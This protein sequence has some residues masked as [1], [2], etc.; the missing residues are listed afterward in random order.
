M[1]L[2]GQ[3]FTISAGEFEAT[4]VEVGAGLRRLTHRGVDL[5]VSY[6]EDRLP[7]KCCGVA[8][9]P[10]PNRIRH[11][12]YVF[13]GTEQQLAL[14]EPDKGNA[15][16]GFGRWSRWRPTV[17]QPS[18]VTLEFDVPPQKGYPFEVRVELTY[19][20]H[21]E[22]GL[23]VT[24]SAH[25]HGRGPAPFGAGFHPYLST[26]GAGLD[27]THIS[28]PARQRL[29]LDDAGVPVGVQ[30]VAGTPYDLR[31]GKRLKDL[32]M[33]A[34]FTGLD[35][36][37]GR[38]AAEVWSSGGGARLWFDATFRYLQVF[39]LDDVE[40]AGPGIAIEPMTCAAD[41]FNSTEGLIVL[42]PGGTWGGS[43]GIQPL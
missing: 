24:A 3:Q 42:H 8:L 34:G 35:L 25:N 4:I 2:T 39:T 29:L 22:L 13:D 33:D 15:I 19:Q 30:S 32:R 43:W 7:P 17:E 38:G 9:V 20:L 16:H 26:H 31:R 37:N 41:A 28:L 40:G 18:R 10:W 14:S 12:R 36:E 27:A 11:G 21:P 23:S 1:T 5:T 6:P